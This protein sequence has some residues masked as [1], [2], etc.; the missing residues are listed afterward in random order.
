M[1]SSQE[2]TY[3]LLMDY[4]TG[5]R[6][7]VL[8]SNSP[9]YIR[10]EIGSWASLSIG[11]A[12]GEVEAN[13]TKRNGGSYINL[14]FNFFKEYIVTLLAAIVGALI[15]YFFPQW[16]L[17]SFAPSYFLRL[18]QGTFNIILLGGIILFFAIVMVV[19]GYAASSTRKRFID[20][21]N[22]FAQSLQSK[23]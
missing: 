11:N 13:I 19:A 7:R 22:M 9:S 8:T 10:A 4:F 16:V 3:H 14:S 5:R 17:S 12:K 15:I 20:E 18:F 2:E 6:E 23:K 21:F 1:N